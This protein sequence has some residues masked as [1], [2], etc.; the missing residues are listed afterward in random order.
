MQYSYTSQNLMHVL[1][2]FILNITHNQQYIS[3]NKRNYSTVNKILSKR[4]SYSELF[5]FNK[6]IIIPI[7][8]WHVLFDYFNMKNK[9]Q[10]FLPSD[11]FLL[12][13]TLLKESDECCFL[14]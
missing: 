8:Y 2:C 10:L 1:K 11:D 13:L 9:I 3:S 14:E 7:F 12:M 5:F 6:A 4:F